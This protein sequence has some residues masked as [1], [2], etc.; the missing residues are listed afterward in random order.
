MAIVASSTLHAVVIALRAGAG[1]EQ[2]PGDHRDLDAPAARAGVPFVLGTPEDRRAGPVRAM[3]PPPGSRC[4]ADRHQKRRGSA[5][6]FRVPPFSAESE[7]G[8]PAGDDSGQK[9]ATSRDSGAG[10][11]AGLD[12]GDRS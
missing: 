6:A 9:R 5:V 12:A 3:R 7:G 1:D 11:R 8:A 4:R 10:N 2:A